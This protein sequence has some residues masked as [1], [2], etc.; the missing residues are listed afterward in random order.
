MTDDHGMSVGSGRID[1]LVELEPVVA[2]LLERHLGTAR[3]WFP[4]QYIPWSRGADFEGPLGGSSWQSDQSKLSTAARSSLVLNLLTEDN[5]PSYHYTFATTVSRDGA[6]GEW[7]NRWTAEEDRHAA[8]IRG[9]LH[10]SR[11]VDPVELERARM[12][13]LSAGFTATHQGVLH[14]LAYVTVQELATRVAHRNAGRHSGDPVCER[15]MTRIAADENL[16][17]VFYRELLRA[18]LE[19]APGPAL[20]AILQAVRD[21]RMP[22]HASPDFARLAMDVALGGIYHVGHFHEEV[23]VPLLRSLGVLDLP[24]VGTAG[25]RCQEE[26]GDFLESLRDE[27]H[28]F[29]ERRRRLLEGRARWERLSGADGPAPAGVGGPAKVC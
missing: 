1:W 6:W 25:R 13:Q 20:A 21:F 18:A 10:T 26:L 16:H 22:S 7:L 8:A 11:A 2:R 23:A 29:E 5:L 12:R 27:S 3:E 14:G 28:G 15:L 9:Y 4:H 24:A 17:M 19:I